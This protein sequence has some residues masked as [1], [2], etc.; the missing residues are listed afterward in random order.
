MAPKD[1]GQCIHHIGRQP[2]VV[3][4]EESVVFVG[5]MPWSITEEELHDAFGKCGEIMEIRIQEDRDGRRRG[6]GFLEFSTPQGARAAMDLNGIV[7]G[8][9][10]LRVDL[11]TRS[12][13]YLLC[14]CTPCLVFASS[15]NISRTYIPRHARRRSLLLGILGPE[16]QKRGWTST[17][18]SLAAVNSALT[19]SPAAV[20]RSPRY[21]S[22]QLSRPS[23]SDP[24]VYRRD[25]GEERACCYRGS[26]LYSSRWLLASQCSAALG[27]LVECIFHI[28]CIFGC[29]V[30]CWNFVVAARLLIQFEPL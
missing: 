20:C 22:R 7:V 18:S 15:K 16:E 24:S 11:T 5:N 1:S 14:H 29:L 8:G 21:H 10:E 2:V 13:V 6:F 17:V 3:H 25:L 28:V 30:S 12:G 26:F 23:F 19:R 4:A 9:R 27:T